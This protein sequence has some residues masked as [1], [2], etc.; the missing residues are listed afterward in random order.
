MPEPKI[1]LHGSREKDPSYVPKI[2]TRARRVG[3]S[4]V[5]AGKEL[6]SAIVGAGSPDPG[7]KGLQKI[8]YG[9]T[10]TAVE[11][12]QTLKETF[13]PPRYEI[14]QEPQYQEYALQEYPPSGYSYESYYHRRQRLGEMQGMITLPVVKYPVKFRPIREQPVNP[15][16][17]A[18]AMFG[19]VGLF[20]KKY[21]CPYCGFRTN[22][23]V[24]PRCGRR[25]A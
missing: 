4:I 6:G 12:Q 14:P 18:K 10:P 15:F 23:P 16:K 7:V 19:N 9:R 2:K 21:Q 24:C 13:V 8:I 22:S 1:G 17:R 25:I 11:K 3:E 20:A 5:S